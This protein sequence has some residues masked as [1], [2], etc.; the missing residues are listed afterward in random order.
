VVIFTI[1]KLVIENKHGIQAK[2]GI[3]MG[4][5]LEFK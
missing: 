2:G 3:S 5:C 4:F 1:L